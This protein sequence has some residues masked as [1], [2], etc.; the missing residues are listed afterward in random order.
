MLTGTKR[1]VIVVVCG[2]A[3]LMLVPGVGHAHGISQKKANATFRSYVKKRL[4]RTPEYSA[5]VSHSKRE[6]S[7][8]HCRPQSRHGHAHVARC[9]YMA[10]ILEWMGEPTSPDSYLTDEYAHRFCANPNSGQPRQQHNR[11]QVRL[12][13]TG[14]PYV[15]KKSVRWTCRLHDLY[16]A[17]TP[18]KPKSV[19]AKP[20]SV[21]PAVP[22]VQ[23]GAPVPPKAP[24]IPS[25]A[26]P[27]AP[28]GPP[29]SGRSFA[30]FSRAAAAP[31]G[32]PAAHA[33]QNGYLRG[34]TPVQADP[35]YRRYWIYTCYYQYADPPPGTHPQGL[36]SWKAQVFYYAGAGLGWAFWFELEW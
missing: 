10:S 18:P 17:D 28:T 1:S 20:P 13:R 34:C 15:V 4:A 16:K 29:G 9:Y 24:S 23:A 21:Q 36:T 25:S 6:I 35:W 14:R 31:G 12:S 7:Q 11:A 2:I 33:A 8:I 19:A 22:A 30:G 3:S 26:P 5:R 27:G 32:A